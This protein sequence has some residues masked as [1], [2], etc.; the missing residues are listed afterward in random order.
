MVP[1]SAPKVV[2]SASALKPVPA[3]ATVKPAEKGASVA[4]DSFMLA[5][6]EKSGTL[7]INQATEV[8]TG[9]VV[10]AATQ[11]TLQSNN[12]T[13]N[14]NNED[15]KGENNGEGNDDDDSTMDVDS[16]FMMNAKFL[17]SLCLEEAL[18]EALMEARK[19]LYFL[20]MDKLNLCVL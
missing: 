8:S 13:G 15:G 2:A 14:K 18:Q 11:E 19:G 1:L 3:M 20:I 17:E 5:G 6:T 7:I 16:S 12:D 10:G 4:K 9:K